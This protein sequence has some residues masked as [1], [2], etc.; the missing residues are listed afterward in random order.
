VAVGVRHVD[1]LDQLAGQR[2][3]VGDRGRGGH[4]GYGREADTSRGREQR[5]PD[6]ECR[7]D[8]RHEEFLSCFQG[9]RRRP[10]RPDSIRAPA[11]HLCRKL[12]H[13]SSRSRGTIFRSTYRFHMHADPLGRK[14]DRAAEREMKTAATKRIGQRR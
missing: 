13:R 10:D 7:L 11:A 9:F 2:G 8:G 14:E 3:P 12:S 6:A 4:R 5:D 1:L